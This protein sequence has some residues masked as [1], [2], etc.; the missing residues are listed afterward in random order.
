MN[1]PTHKTTKPLQTFEQWDVVVVPFPFVDMPVQKVRPA[2]VLSVRDAN[3]QNGH[4][5]LSMIT[6]ASRSHWASDVVITGLSE[7]GLQA[8]SL[9][10]CKLFTLPNAL[11]S[12]KIGALDAADRKTCTNTFRNLLGL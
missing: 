3:R 5:L 8:S 6:T 1:G 2:L 9:V 10:R 11:I 4:T 12:R 7:A